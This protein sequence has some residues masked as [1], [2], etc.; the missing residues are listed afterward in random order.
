MY[1]INDQNAAIRAIQWYLYDI[2]LYRAEIPCVYPDGIYGYDTSQCVAALQRQHGLEVTGCVDFPTFVLLRELHSEIIAR[3]LPRTRFNPL[4]R[5]LDGDSLKKGE[6]SAYISFIQL[7]LKTLS[8]I[9]PKMEN[10]EVT[11]VFDNET[12]SAIK[13]FQRIDNIPQTGTV[14]KDTW[15]ALNKAYEKYVNWDS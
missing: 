1:N 13:D 7:M 14:D 5:N 10:I 4:P 3:S 2:S 11:G 6:E 8:V 15:N 12:E 9:Y